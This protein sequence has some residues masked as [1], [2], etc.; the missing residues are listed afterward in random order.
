M[1]YSPASDNNSCF[2]SCAEQNGYSIIWANTGSQELCLF[3]QQT[4]TEGHVLDAQ[5][6]AK[7]T[8]IS[9]TSFQ[10]QKGVS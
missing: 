6:K 4:N 10:S 8:K 7:W 5:N 2:C 3:I 9:A 1:L